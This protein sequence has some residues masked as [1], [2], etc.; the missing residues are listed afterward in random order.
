MV[1][2]LWNVEWMNPFRDSIDIFPFLLKV[3]KLQ[4]L[5]H[6]LLQTEKRGQDCKQLHLPFFLRLVRWRSLNLHGN[7]GRRGRTTAK[8]SQT[9]AS[10]VEAKTRVPIGSGNLE[11]RTDLF[12][13]G[14][15]NDFSQIAW[16]HLENEQNFWKRQEKGTKVKS[17]ECFVYHCEN[18]ISKT[19]E[20]CFCVFGC[21]SFPELKVNRWSTWRKRVS[22]E[23]NKCYQEAFFW[24]G[25]IRAASQQQNLLCRSSHWLWNLREGPISGIVLSLCLSEIT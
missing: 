5:G 10:N 21:I 18:P 15:I 25:S 2:C 3:A 8:T 22:L 13:S 1:P 4:R 24:T 19:P 12:Q 9:W 23:P 14:K 17:F 6:L 16:N 7:S 11:K 20:V